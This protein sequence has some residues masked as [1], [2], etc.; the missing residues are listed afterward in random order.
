MGYSNFGL[1]GVY[2]TEVFYNIA[3]HSTAF[4]NCNWTVLRC[5]KIVWK[6]FIKNKF[7]SS[8]LRS[9]RG[10]HLEGDHKKAPPGT[11]H[12]GHVRHACSRQVRFPQR[13]RHQ[14]GNGHVLHVCADP[15]LARFVNSRDN[16]VIAGHHFSGDV[17]QTPR[18]WYSL[19]HAHRYFTVLYRHS[20]PLDGQWDVWKHHSS[21]P[22]GDASINIFWFP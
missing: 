11:Q 5:L 12:H 9:A 14:G 10:L 15:P 7:F 21:N 18:I 16:V 6:H 1:F 19:R 20:L 22:R 2:C 17:G 3:A 13:P 8:S 4:F